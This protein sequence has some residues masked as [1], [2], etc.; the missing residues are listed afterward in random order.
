MSNSTCS[1]KNSNGMALLL[2]IS[3]L[4]QV[5]IFEKDVK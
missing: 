4:V 3:S 2:E 1:I 5:T